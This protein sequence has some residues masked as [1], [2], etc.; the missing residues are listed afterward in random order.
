MKLLISYRMR[1][2][3]QQLQRLRDLGFE[4]CL[5]SADRGPCPPEYMDAQAVVCYLLF[6]YNDI[7]QFPNL[8]VIHTTSA[9]LDHMPMDY[10]RE[11]GIS[12]YNAG[13][14]YSA[15]MA[16]FALC[17][18]LQLYKHAPAF[19]AQQLRHEWKQ[20]YRLLELGGKRVC[21]VGAGSIGAETAKR[22]SAMG[23]RVTGLCRRP[24][25]KEYFDEVRAV[26]ELDAVLPEADIVI[27]SLPLSGET[28]HMMDA[29]RFALMKKGSVLVNISRGPVADTD[30]L[31]AASRDGTLL[32]AVVDVC[33]SEPLEA[34]SPLWEQENIILTPHN[35]FVGD[36]NTDRM[37]ELIYADL[38]DWMLTQ[39]GN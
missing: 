1:F 31:L 28:R 39:G 32:G 13:G 27:L 7:A 19:R 18:V 29:R 4:I 8:R 34:D 21:I 15:P 17:G 11:H 20:D 36:G 9:G 12:L 10:I 35:S 38:R 2:S 30:A 37:F 3:E 24:G 5:A 33:E 14:V 23:C 26:S 6:N 16:E 25:P 22:F